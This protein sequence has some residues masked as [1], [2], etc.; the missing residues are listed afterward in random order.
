MMVSWMIILLEMLQKVMLESK[1]AKGYLLL[2]ENLQKTS[3]LSQTSKIEQQIANLTSLQIT[4]DNI[5]LKN[6]QSSSSSDV[7]ML[8]RLTIH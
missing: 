3:Q 7:R 8:L 5:M 4:K 6:F 1:T 2:V